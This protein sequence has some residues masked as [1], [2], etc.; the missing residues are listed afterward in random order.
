MRHRID[1]EEIANAVFVWLVLALLSVAG[2]FVVS[3]VI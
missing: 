1:F 3:L 2:W